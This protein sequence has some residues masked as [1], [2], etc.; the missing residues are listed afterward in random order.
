MPRPPVAGVPFVPL[1]SLLVMLVGVG[2]AAAIGIAGMDHLTRAAEARAE[3]R[4]ALVADT[5]AARLGPLPAAARR[6]ATELTA[7]RTAA[8][9]VL[10]TQAGDVVHDVSLGVPE[11]PV[12]V[13]MIERGHGSTTGRLGRARFSVGKVDGPNALRV[14]ALVAEPSS[15]ESAPAMLVALVALVTLLLAASAAV[16]H[17]VSRDLSRD[18]DF[19]TRRVRG[20]AQVRSEPTGE[21]VPVRSLDEPGAL[22]ATFNRLVERFAVAE[23]A[24][25]ADL[26]RAQ[27]G[28]QERAAFLAAMSHEL[29]SP[30]N[31]IL[32]FADVLLAEVDGPLTADA[33]D[34]V[35]QIR[36]SGTHLSTLIHDILELSALESGQLRL[37]PKP[38]DVVAIASEVVR[39]ARGVVGDRPLTLSVT[40]EA[41]LV[42][43]VDARRVRQILGN[44]VSNAIKFTA[45]GSVQVRVSRVAYMAV[46]EVVDT[47]PGIGEEERARVFQEFKQARGEAK[48][49]RGTGLGLAIARRLVLL[50]HGTIH[51]DSKLGAGSTFVVRLPLGMS[52]SKGEGP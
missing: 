5:L 30:L 2:V 51:V 14:I 52:G 8:E 12:L 45:S 37:E 22:T 35:Q 18:V 3:D 40:G 16:A 4:A 10:V 19:F 15:P 25:R 50:H 7:R 21:L 23:R 6:E 9:L 47:G 39:E 32:G 13:G 41:S 38:A 11:R 49:R 44:L 28:D 24:Y 17:A 29:R 43:R 33:R 46:L 34:E 31:A 36:D 1:A 20:M 26:E 27:R 48:Q 42:A